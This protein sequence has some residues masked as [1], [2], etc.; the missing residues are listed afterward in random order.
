MCMLALC[1]LPQDFFKVY[2]ERLQARGVHLAQPYRRFYDWVRKAKLNQ[3]K[4]RAH[5]H[6][7]T[8]HNI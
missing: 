8:Q 7:Q 4:V 1:V 5:T 6:A 2:W 3:D